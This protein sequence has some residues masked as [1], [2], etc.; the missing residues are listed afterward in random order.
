MPSDIGRLIPLESV[1]RFFD[2]MQQ[3]QSIIRRVSVPNRDHYENDV[4]H[5]Y[6]LAMMAWYL[7]SAFELGYDTDK[8]LRK[9][10]VHDLVEVITGDVPW[11]EQCDP[12]ETRRLELE[13]INAIAE[14]FTEFPDLAIAIREY[15]TAHEPEDLFIREL[16]KVMANIT[17]YRSGG[18]VWQK[19]DQSFDWLH[20]KTREKV[21]RVPELVRLMDHLHEILADLPHLFAP[22]EPAQLFQ[23]G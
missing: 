2:F 14:Q 7:N 18:G 5:S 12:E 9:A 22:P 4:E 23:L 8:L 6:Q 11:T 17:I 16:D 15:E 20:A 19:Y 1:L 3:F 21:F 10:L 13:A